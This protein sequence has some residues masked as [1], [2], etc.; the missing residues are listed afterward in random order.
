MR[1]LQCPA[2]RQQAMVVSQCVCERIP[3]DRILLWAREHEAISAD[4]VKLGLGCGR[5]CGLCVAFIQYA[6][7]TGV[8][9][10]PYP[11]PS[12]PPDQRQRTCC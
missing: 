11:C 1:R 3:F 9:S 5:Q 4:Q 8:T 6:L 7:Q 12:L 2:A 10:V